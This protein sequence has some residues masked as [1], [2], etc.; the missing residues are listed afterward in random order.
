M[1]FDDRD[2]FHRF[3]VRTE[4]NRHGPRRVL[5]WFG[6]ALLAAA[7]LQTPALAQQNLLANPGFEEGLDETTGLPVGWA[8]FSGDAGVHLV[9]TPDSSQFT[10]DRP[11]PVTASAASSCPPSPGRS[12]GPR[13]W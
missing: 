3:R 12:T 1:A 6:L 2:R 4:L 13:P 5:G 11:R 7:L 10:T 8:L 9:L